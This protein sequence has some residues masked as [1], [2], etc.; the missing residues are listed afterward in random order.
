VVFAVRGL[1]VNVPL[2]GWSPL[3]PPEALQDCALVALHCKVVELPLGTLL[4][5]AIRVTAGFAVPLELAVAVLPVEE[6]V[7]DVSADDDSPQAASAANTAH[8]SVHPNTR[9]TK[10]IPRLFDFR[11]WHPLPSS[12]LAGRLAHLGE[13]D[14]RLLSWICQRV[15]IRVLVAD[16]RHL[17]AIRGAYVEDSYVQAKI[18]QPST[19]PRRG[20]L[21]IGAMVIGRV[22]AE[23]AHPQASFT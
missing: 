13:G 21:Q 19:R 2:I 15:A 5:L 12:L 17:R 10:L 11:P 6:L 8:P 20:K 9:P 14:N 16:L 18:D 7:A 3:H 1:V 4:F 22:S 23:P